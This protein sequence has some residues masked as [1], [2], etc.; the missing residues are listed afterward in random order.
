MSRHRLPNNK[1]VSD[2]MPFELEQSIL[3]PAKRDADGQVIEPQRYEQQTIR[4]VS[5]VRRLTVAE[6]QTLGIVE[7]VEQPRPDERFYFVNENPNAPGQWIVTPRPLNQLKKQLKQLVKDIAQSLIL[8]KYPL[9]KQINL[10]SERAELIQKRATG[11]N[12]TAGEQNKVTAIKNVID[13][14]RSVT[15]HSDTLET[16]IEALANVEAVAAWVPHDWP[17]EFAPIDQGYLP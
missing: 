15:D 2:D 5:G 12:W 7:I 16:E 17:A 14:I 3:I 11:G 9:W 8:A 10:N 4:Y 13:K 6:R 1:I